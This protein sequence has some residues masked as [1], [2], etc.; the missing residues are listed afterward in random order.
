MMQSTE[1]AVGKGMTEPMKSVLKQYEGNLVCFPADPAYFID[2][3]GLSVF[4]ACHRTSCLQGCKTQ[5]ENPAMLATDTKR[6]SPYFKAVHAA[7]SYAVGVLADCFMMRIA[8]GFCD[9]RCE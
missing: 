5:Q 6:N 3:V 2:R 1:M 8:A 7:L 9:A 4:I